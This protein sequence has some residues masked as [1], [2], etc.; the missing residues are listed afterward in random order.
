MEGFKANPKMKSE[1]A[2]FKEGG[3]TNLPFKKKEKAESHE[4]VAMDKKVVK[5]AVAQHEGAKHKGEPKTELKLKNGGR[6]KKDGGTVGRYKAGGAV[7][8]K[9]DKED[10][11][12][13]A[14]V[15]RMQTPK[16]AA[17]SA[18]SSMPAAAG[19]QN[20]AGGKRVAPRFFNEEPDDMTAP[21]PK[22]AKKL[23][24]PAKPKLKN[25][26]PAP[27]APNAMDRGMTT[28]ERKIPPMTYDYERGQI[29]EMFK[30]GPGD[31]MRGLEAVG[32]Y[33]GGGKV[34][35]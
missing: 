35:C 20:L 8:M 6:C 3:S 34:G 2:C 9:K 7:A 19:L 25:I 15:K 21:P 24:M 12:K 26:T 33:M 18:A 1:I 10:K 4:D 13:I 32:K 28:M 11:K 27:M 14:N 5:K 22:G 29:E 30:D 23:P 17:P 31:V 16:A